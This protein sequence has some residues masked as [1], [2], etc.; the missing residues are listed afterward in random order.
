[1]NIIYILFFINF[2]EKFNNFF[3][4]LKLLLGIGDWGLGIGDWGLGIGANAQAAIPHTPYS[5]VN[6]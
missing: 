1:M 2:F 4:V 3:F 6:V 5:T